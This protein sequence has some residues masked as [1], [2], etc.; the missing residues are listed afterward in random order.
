MSNILL[1][2]LEKI[3]K[4]HNQIEQFLNDKFHQN[5]PL[6]YNSVD[7]RHS[8]F[9]VAPVDT[10]CFP[11]GFNNLSNQSVI[12]AGEVVNNFLGT[13]YPN[14]YKILIL[15]EN[16]TRNLRYLENILA[17]NK[18]LQS[19]GREVLVGS[20][21]EEIDDTLEI[22]L[23]NNQKI[24]L[25]KLVRNDNKISTKSGFTPD[26]II[27]NNDFTDGI[28]PILQNISQ[29]ITPTPQM[30]WHIRKK[31]VHFNNYNQIINQFCQLID[32][33]PWL[34]STMHRNCDDVNFKEQKGIECLAKYVDELISHL[35]R[36]YQQYNIQ[37]SPYCYIKADKGT[38]GMAVMTVSSG[39]EILEINKKERNKM[40]SLKGSI[41][42]TT[43]IIQEGVLTADRVKSS[44][45]EPLI[46]LINGQVVGNLFRINNDR[47]ANIS[48]NSSG[49]SF[50]DLNILADNELSLGL[51]RD[52]VVKIYSLIAR[53]SALAA[54][55]EKY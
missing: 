48:L 31:S 28:P 12:R 22:D 21:I 38:Y 14:T 24:T 18:I 34:I 26:I 39:A 35:K 8:G 3:D 41:Q 50:C 9:K 16:H 4:Y 2:L 46:Y 33:D 13:K 43:A 25:H 54:S 27:A 23:E 29:P 52:D 53:L 30:G 40:N 32:L 5:S 55:C 15:P 51:K 36:K 1:L 6:F 45:A 37:S 17:L 19:Q 47:D 7:L 44:I 42:N 10:N 11:A 49:M 20:L